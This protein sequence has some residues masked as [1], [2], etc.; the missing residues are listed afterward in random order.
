MLKQSMKGSDVLSPS[1]DVESLKG[2]EDFG[3]ENIR[4]PASMKTPRARK[5][6][7]FAMNKMIVEHVFLW[8]REWSMILLS[9]FSV[10]VGLQLL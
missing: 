8:G 2:E 10:A 1:Q 3:W 7:A 6:M 5:P 4:A 9:S